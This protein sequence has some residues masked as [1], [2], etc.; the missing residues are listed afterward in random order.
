MS[1]RNSGDSD[2]MI[3]LDELRDRL[4]GL[5][6]DVSSQFWLNANTDVGVLSAAARPAGALLIFY[7]DGL[8]PDEVALTLAV[9]GWRLAVRPASPQAR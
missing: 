1:P 8:L 9:G 4:A 2:P 6:A 5:D 3:G 7:P